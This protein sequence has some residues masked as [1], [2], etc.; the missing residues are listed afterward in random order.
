MLRGQTQG[1]SRAELMSNALRQAE[2]Y[3]DTMCTT[4]TL[5]NEK[6]DAD[7]VTNERF[8]GNAVALGQVSFSADFT[9]EIEHQWSKPSYGFPKC[10]KCDKVK[11]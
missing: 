7:F 10:V 2:A 3:Y 5:T 1:A 11:M 8:C 9:A 6:S 4:V